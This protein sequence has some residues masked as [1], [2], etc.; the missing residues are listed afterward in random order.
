MHV[1]LSRGGSRSRDCRGG[2]Y[3]PICWARRESMTRVWGLCS[4][5]G[6]DAEPPWSWPLLCYYYYY[7]AVFNAPYV[8]QSMTKS[9][10]RETR[11]LRIRRGVIER[12][13]FLFESA[14]S[15]VQVVND[16]VWQ[17]IPNVWSAIGETTT[18]SDLS[19]F[20]QS[21]LA[22][23]QR[24][25]DWKQSCCHMPPP[26]PS[27]PAYEQFLNLHIDLGSF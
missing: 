20:R 14:C 10:A 4:Q 16:V 17:R 1:L 13:Q 2:A 9:Q 22:S 11:E 18:A 25:T 19:G 8:C 26:L 21:P 3:R 6:P 15:N 7:Y 23:S 5:W 12:L 27:A 24:W